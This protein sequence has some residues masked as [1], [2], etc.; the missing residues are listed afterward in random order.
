M[1]LPQLVDAPRRQR[2]TFVGQRFN[3]LR[4]PL[5]KECWRAAAGAL[6]CSIFNP[7]DSPVKPELPACHRRCVALGR[8]SRGG[9][10]QLLIHMVSRG[11]DGSERKGRCMWLLSLSGNNGNSNH[12]ENVCIELFSVEAQWTF[13][14]LTAK[15]DF[16]VAESDEWLM[17][18]RVRVRA[19]HPWRAEILEEMFD[20][21]SATYCSNS[22]GDVCSL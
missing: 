2:L 18:V 13:D 14:W 19:H 22:W 5:H 10:V 21:H 3:K 6:L 11:N 17:V 15:S 1:A 4:A 20:P 8:P 9:T 12:P 16:L 7:A